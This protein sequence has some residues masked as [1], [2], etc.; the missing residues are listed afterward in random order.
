[1][2]GCGPNT[3]TYCYGDNDYHQWAYQCPDCQ[4][5]GIRFLEGS[6]GFGDVGN[7]YNGL[8]IQNLA[9]VNLPNFGDLTNELFTSGAPSTDHALVMEVIADNA[10]SCLDADPLFGTSQPWKWIVACYDGCSQPQAT[11][12]TNCL[13]STT[14]EV[15]VN[16][17]E[18]GNTGTVTI[19]NDGGAVAVN[20]SAVGT[21]TVGPFTSGTPVRINVEGA[22]VL[23]TWTSPAMNPDCSDVGMEELR[24]DR[25]KIHP[26]PSSGT[27]FLELPNGMAS[28]AVVDVMD[29]TG[30]SVAQEI[31]SG[32]NTTL[33]LEHLPNGLYTVMANSNG[34]RFTTKIS[35]QH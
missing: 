32:K 9:P 33:H 10:M 3:Y 27:F 12:A 18:V 19:T 26:N 7:I 22:S 13:T 15:F 1:M 21:Y 34:Q 23:C 29:L 14:F 11:F 35:V 25:M 6:M 28:G 8:D 31:L 4:E 17:T 30:R 2:D 16:V 24:A 5:I 20:A